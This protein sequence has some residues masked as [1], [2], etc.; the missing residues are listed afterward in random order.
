MAET[1]PEV[2][3]PA[4]RTSATAPSPSDDPAA[5][6]ALINQI[7]ADLA[8]SVAL[9]SQL[10]EMDDPAHPDPEAE[11]AALEAAQAATEAATDLKETVERTNHELALKRT[12]LEVALRG[13]I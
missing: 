12:R 9:K 13:G 4:G 8:E 6:Q 7:T 5:K 11:A 10:A 2:S 3:A 1:L